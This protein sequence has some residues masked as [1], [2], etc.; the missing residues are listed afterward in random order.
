MQQILEDLH[1]PIWVGSKEDL[2]EITRDNRKWAVVHAC[3]TAHKDKLGYEKSLPAS[4]PNYLV[5]EDRDDIYLNL[6]DME[7]EFMPVY[8]DPIFQKAFNFIQ[9]ALMNGQNVLIYC[10]QG[11]SRSP[12]IAMAYLAMNGYFFENSHEKTK[13][14][15]SRLYDYRPGKGVDLYLKNNWERLKSF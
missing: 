8:T 4:D 9:A 13:A 7:R 14:E 11:H 3:K 15:F 5:A 1:A 2:Q 10:D 12:S 6:V